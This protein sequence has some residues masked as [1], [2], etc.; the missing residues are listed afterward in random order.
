M[1]QIRIKVKL[2]YIW[3]IMFFVSFFML[4]FSWGGYWDT[5]PAQ[6]GF[7]GGLLRVTV[8]NLSFLPYMFVFMS[9]SL[10]VTGF[11]SWGRKG[12]LIAALMFILAAVLFVIP[13]I[14]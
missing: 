13:S 14:L 8:Y 4:F 5:Y 6:C 9:L 1:R 10:F 11:K 12:L 2:I 7:F 3:K